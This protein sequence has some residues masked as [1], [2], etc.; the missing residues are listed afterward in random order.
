MHIT[1]IKCYGV[2]PSPLKT[3]MHSSVGYDQLRFS[4][5]TPVSEK[6]NCVSSITAHVHMKP[7]NARSLVS[8]VFVC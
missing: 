5:R 1:G 6:I 4:N 7:Q 3:L 8:Y 2:I